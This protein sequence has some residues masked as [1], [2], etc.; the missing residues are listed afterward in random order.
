MVASLPIILSFL[1]SSFTSQFIFWRK[2]SGNLSW[3]FIFRYCPLTKQE[4]SV[5]AKEEWLLFSQLDFWV[6]NLHFIIFVIYFWRLRFHVYCLQTKNGLYLLCLTFLC[7]LFL[8]VYSLY[9]SLAHRRPAYNF[10]STT[11]PLWLSHSLVNWCT[12][13]SSS[14]LLVWVDLVQFPFLRKTRTRRMAACSCHKTLSRTAA[15]KIAMN[16]RYL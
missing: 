7:F 2:F 4:T 9:L 14:A 15:V 3:F 8:K 5:V 1:Y 13:L 11:T 16:V 12:R 6:W 10:L